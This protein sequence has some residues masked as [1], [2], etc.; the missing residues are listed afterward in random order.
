MNTRSTTEDAVLGALA[1]GPL[2]VSQLLACGSVFL[3]AALLLSKRQGTAVVFEAG[4]YWLV[5][6]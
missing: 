4:R 3:R 6:R 5:V 2:T 1:Q